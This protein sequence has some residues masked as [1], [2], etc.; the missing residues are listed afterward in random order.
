MK[1]LKFLLT[2]FATIFISI[3]IIFIG[4]V[5]VN[6]VD[7]IFQSSK[8]DVNYKFNYKQIFEEI[9]VSSFDKNLLHGLLFKTENAKGLVFYLHGN[10]GNLSSW[11]DIST[12][13]TDLGYDI[14][15]LDYRG[16]GKSQRKIS[17]ETQ[18]NQ[19]VFA[20]YR[21]MCLRYQESKIVVVGYSIGSG[22]AAILAVNNSPKALILQAPYYSFDEL[23]DSRVPFFPS[24]LKNFKFE[25]FTYIEKIKAPIYVF[26]GDQDEVIDVVNSMRLTKLLRSK[27][28]FVLLKNQGHVGVNENFTFQTEL[29]KILE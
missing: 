29:K 22:P 9:T 13:Y 24:F 27:D 2:S 17:N 11:G 6:Q 14:F 12:I 18:L 16:F 4:Y 25:T 15:I 3:Y 23:S 19:D 28:T 5:Y 20:A 21:K 1:T 26:H 8:L 7:I 10:A